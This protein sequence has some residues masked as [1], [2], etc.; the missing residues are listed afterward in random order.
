MKSGANHPQRRTEAACGQGAG[1]T[2]GQQ[3][4]LIAL[5]LADQ[6]DAQLGHGQIG[7][8][9]TLM[10]ADGFGLQQRQRVVMA[11]QPTQPL[12]HAL[13]RPEQ[14][15]RGRPRCSQQVEIR[16]QCR[17]PVAAFLQTSPYSQ[18]NRIG[19]TDA[20]GRRAAHHHATDRLG[21]IC[22]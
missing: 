17:A 10:N 13:K 11:F 2:M 6:I 14:I 22:R 7:F 21:D 5:V 15:D 4:L 19:R 20:D 8:T 9:I 18:D 12:T 16:L 1:I 3:V